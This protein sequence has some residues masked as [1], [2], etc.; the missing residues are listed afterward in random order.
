[1]LAFEYGLTPDK[2]IKLT[3]RE[4]SQLLEGMGAR[5][6]GYPETEESTII[7]EN[8]LVDDKIKRLNERRF[9]G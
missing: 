5:K 1:L 8:P 6:N 9:N 4:I 3:R 7:E 2:A